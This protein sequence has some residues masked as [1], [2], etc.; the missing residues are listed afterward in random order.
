[1]QRDQH[2]SLRTNVANVDE[3]RFVHAAHAKNPSCRLDNSAYGA[4]ASRTTL[5]P[6]ARPRPLR[7]ATIS[8]AWVTGAIDTATSAALSRFIPDRPHRHV[9]GPGATG[10]RRAHA[11]IA[12]RGLSLRTRYN[13]SSA[14]QPSPLTGPAGL[15]TGPPSAALPPLTMP[16]ATL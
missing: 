7:A 16:R 3:L 1:M 14:G 15:G 9:L 12:A 2:G 8:G 4:K 13:A 5:H 6:R 11:V 10:S